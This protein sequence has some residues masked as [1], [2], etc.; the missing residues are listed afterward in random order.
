MNDT[1]SNIIENIKHKVQTLVLM[2]EKVRQE[3]DQLKAQVAELEAK[4]KD[5]DNAC[6]E[7]EE[8]YTRLKLAKALK[9]GELDVHEAK[10]KVNRIV[11]EIDR[12][13]ALLNK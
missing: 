5:K 12:C 11:R 3:N 10:I 13:I 7:L 2:Y 6:A 1:S 9:S 4:L 8:R